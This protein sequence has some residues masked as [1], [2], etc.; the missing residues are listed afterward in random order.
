MAKR[1][2]LVVSAQ[3]KAAALRPLKQPLYDTSILPAAGGLAVQFFA[4]PL[5]QAMPVT[6]VL[7]TLADT[8]MQQAGQ[9]G[10][11]NMFELYGFKFKYQQSV[12]VA[13]DFDAIYDTGVFTF[14][15]GQQ[16]PW[17]QI[18]LAQIPAGTMPTGANT[19]DGQAAPGAEIYSLTN[20]P[21]NT[22]SY[23]NFTIQRKAILIGSN[24]VF[25]ATVT[26]PLGAAAVTANT[27]V[28]V[29]LVGI[30]HRAI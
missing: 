12:N 28:Q 2:G 25:G 3:P 29:Y 30:F 14:N 11:P 16:R 19:I 7:K 24:E 13:A 1:A 22:N 4:I 27:R 18:P 8:N 26:Y 20:G 9:L 23:Y 5:G 17:L 21:S 15:F 10:T 6:G